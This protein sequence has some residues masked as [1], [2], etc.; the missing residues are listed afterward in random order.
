[1]SVG[2][3]LGKPYDGKDDL[4]PLAPKRFVEGIIS[5]LPQFNERDTTQSPA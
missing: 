4:T 2:V 1:M 3:K 5:A